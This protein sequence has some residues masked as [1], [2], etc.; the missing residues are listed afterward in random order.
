MRRKSITS[1]MA[2]FP[3]IDREKLGT[4][5]QTTHAVRLGTTRNGKNVSSW[6]G[7]LIDG[8]PLTHPCLDHIDKI[9]RMALANSES[10]QK[11]NM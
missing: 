7:I 6:S 3:E 2:Q 11:K 9:G 1:L 8:G 4:P 5:F 10:P